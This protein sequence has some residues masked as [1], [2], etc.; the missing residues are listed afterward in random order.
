MKKISFFSF[1]LLL[2]LCITLMFSGCDKD[3]VVDTPPISD[4]VLVSKSFKV[5]DLK[6]SVKYNYPGE[7]ETF[8]ELLKCSYVVSNITSGTVKYHIK[9]E[10]IEAVPEHI[11]EYCVAEACHRHKVSERPEEWRITEFPATFNVGGKTNPN[12]DGYI[13]MMPAISIVDATPGLNKFRVTYYNA[14][15]ESDFVR[16]TLIFNFLDVPFQ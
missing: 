5:D 7:I 14:E 11:M 2:G 9:I 3:K 1:S 8:F 12:T 4:N 13:G 15:D 10:R 6:D 16:F